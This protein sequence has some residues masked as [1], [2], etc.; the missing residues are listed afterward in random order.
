MQDIKA[1]GRTYEN[2]VEIKYL[3]GR[4]EVFGNYS[5]ISKSDS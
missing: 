5:K 4:I 1:A 3:C 2:L